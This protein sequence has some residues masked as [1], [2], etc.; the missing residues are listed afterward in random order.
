MSMNIF[1]IYYTAIRFALT[2][3]HIATA[4]KEIADL[5][6]SLFNNLFKTRAYWSDLNAVEL[7]V[8]HLYTRKVWQTQR[9]ELHSNN[10]V[11]H[12]KIHKL[13]EY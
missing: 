6:Q 11:I 10:A 13:T 8:H 9:H 5:N 1:L 4:S 12:P 2:L 7:L 3:N